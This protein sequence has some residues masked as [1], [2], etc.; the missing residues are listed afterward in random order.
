[1]VMNSSEVECI[2]SFETLKLLTNPPILIYPDFNK[3]FL[4][5]TDA[6]RSFSR[7]VSCK[8]CEPYVKWLGTKLQYN[9]KSTPTVVIENLALFEK[10]KETVIS[11]N[12]KF[13][14][15]KSKKMLQDV[16]DQN[17]LS[18]MIKKKNTTK[19]TIEVC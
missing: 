6:S 13:R 19:I 4:L 14:I 1:M 18:E 17:E 8:L 10:F 15:Y 2:E 9:R 12:N 3:K 16:S 11:S 7:W 5:Q